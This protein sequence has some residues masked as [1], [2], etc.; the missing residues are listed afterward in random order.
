MS[1][2][3]FVLFVRRLTGL[4]QCIHNELYVKSGGVENTDPMS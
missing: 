3:W 4:N 1:P 2:P